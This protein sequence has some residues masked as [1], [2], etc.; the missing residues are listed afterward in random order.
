MP[1]VGVSVLLCLLVSVLRVSGVGGD[2]RGCEGMI[3]ECCGS[4]CLLNRESAAGG[5]AP[6]S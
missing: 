5:H 3:R 4:L 1:G 6:G 2:V